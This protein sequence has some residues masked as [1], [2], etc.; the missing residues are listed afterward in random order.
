LPL[1][2]HIGEPPPHVE[3]ILDL[4]DAGDVITHCFHGKASHPWELSGEPIP[5]LKR[6]LDRGVLI[7]VGHGAGSFSFEVAKK[8][9]S[10]GNLPF[11]I[12]T[13]AHALNLHGPVYDLPTTMTK[14]MA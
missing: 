13:D 3:D 12:S 4:L 9:I 5:A 7:D 8:A 6:A 10:A 2:V 11:S 1:M 14:M